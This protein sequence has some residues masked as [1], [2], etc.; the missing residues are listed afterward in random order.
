ML[1]ELFN[2][3]GQFLHLVLEGCLFRCRG[4]CLCLFNCV[5]NCNLFCLFC[6]SI[7][8]HCV[9][10]N[11]AV[12]QVH[13]ACAVFLGKLR[14]V[15]DHN[16]KTVAGNFLQ[17]LHNLKTTFGVKCAGGLVCKDDVR[18]VDKG[19]GDC[20][21]LCL[22]ARK[23]VGALLGLVCKANLAESFHCSLNT[24]LF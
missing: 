7:I 22:S 18:I 2:L 21:T 5:H 6:R 3:F 8:G 16:H 24:F 1:F 4:F 13:D 12:L 11:F 23:L 14:V 15:C 17:K 20:D 9:S 19:A 10:N